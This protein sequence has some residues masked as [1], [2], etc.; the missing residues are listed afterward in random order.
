MMRP[1]PENWSA[2]GERWQRVRRKSEPGLTWVSRSL[3]AGDAAGAQ[4]QFQEVLRLE[5]GHAVAHNNLGAIFEGQRNW[6]AAEAHFL[7]AIQSDPNSALAHLNLAMLRVSKKK[8]KAAFEGFREAVALDRSLVAER[9]DLT[10]PDELAQF[11]SAKVE[12]AAHFAIHTAVC[13]SGFE[14]QEE[15]E[16][17]E[18]VHLDPEFIL[19]HYKVGV[20][21]ERLGRYDNAAASYRKALEIR[22]DHAAL[23]YSLGI[24]FANQANYESAKK[25][26]LEALRLDPGY[27]RA[28]NGLGW[29]Y[30]IQERFE[31]AVQE[32]QQYRLTDRSD[33]VEFYAVLWH[34][35][36]LKRLGK[37]E[38]ANEF[39]AKH[40]GRFKEEWVSHL[41]RY[42]RG[43]LSESELLSNARH[44]WQQCE[45]HFY[46]GYRHLLQG[47]RKQA[48]KYFRK[49]V[50]TKR[51]LYWEYHAARAMLQRLSR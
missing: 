44:K 11:R 45:A 24:V 26:F 33:A 34:Y 36:S 10:D 38:E 31:E 15:K 28:H 8:W 46:V 4:T 22:P 32:F 7:K 41:F 16:L 48:R 51:F 18:A 39:L 47:D 37:S 17:R 50:D 23:H 2:F 25:E 29:T 19:A 14:K 20:L 9:L 6:K 3:G 12:A 49:T 40:D 42:H 43:E 27:V 21:Y 13:C 35:L 30:F 5:P 1:E